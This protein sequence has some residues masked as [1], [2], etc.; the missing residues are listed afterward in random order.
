MIYLNDHQT[1]ASQ[2]PKQPFLSSHVALYMGNVSPSLQALEAVRFAVVVDH[3]AIMGKYETL[4]WPRKFSK[5]V[6]NL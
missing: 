6:T 3:Q 1:I 2:C 4:Y 5:K